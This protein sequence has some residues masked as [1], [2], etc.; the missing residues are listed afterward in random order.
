[1]DI[2]DSKQQKPSFC[3]LVITETCMLRCKMCRM[4]QSNNPETLQL[5]T[6][7]RFIDSFADFVEGKAQVQFVGGEPLLKKGVL[8]LISHSA[9]RGLS[10]T[11]TTNGFLIDENTAKDI[12]ASGLNTIVFS[13]ESTKKQTHDFL[14]GVDGVYDRVM[15]AIKFLSKPNNDLIKIHIVTIIMQQ[16]LDDLLELAE[17]AER[18]SAINGISFQAIMQPFFTAVDDDWQKNKE[19]S[20]LWPKI[21]DKVDYTLDKLA[22]FK[23]AGWKIT[24]PVAQFNIYK[25]YFRNPERFVK[26]SRC[27]LGYNS[28]TVDTAGKVF[29]CNSMPPIGDIQEGKDMRELWFSDKAAQVRDNIK[30]CNHNCKL[31][32]NCFFEEEK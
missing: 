24:N 18:N 31:L 12:A 16:N 6:W 2:K 14:R 32:I 3:D 25:S 13:L 9:Q 29:L 23:K 1:M 22:E 21:I 4:W 27:N 17:W 7:G 19:F 8:G 30:N 15:K 26:S 5:D 28:I 11:M 10:T 20:F